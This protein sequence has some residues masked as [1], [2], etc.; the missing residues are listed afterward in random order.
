MPHY[1][2]DIHHQ[3]TYFVEDEEGNDTN[4]MTTLS[5]G[6]PVWPNSLEEWVWDDSRRMAVVAY[7]AVK[8]LGFCNPTRYPLINIHTTAI[9]SMI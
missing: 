2:I 6:I 4:E 8:D 7:D 9:S 5:I 1:A 3:G